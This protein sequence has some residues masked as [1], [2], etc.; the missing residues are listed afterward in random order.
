MDEQHYAEIDATLMYIEE[1]RARAE[2]TAVKLRSEGAGE[3]LVVAVE[4]ARDQLSA[5][6]RK[7]LQQTHFAIPAAQ[8][9]L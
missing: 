1:A 4:H 8:A 7:L 5:T 6:Q 9:S 2:R 3:H